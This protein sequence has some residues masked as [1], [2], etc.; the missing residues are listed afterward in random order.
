MC[1]RDLFLV[2]L[3]CPRHYF[4]LLYITHVIVI[5]SPL[6][7]HISIFITVKSRE[8]VKPYGLTSLGLAARHINHINY[9]IL[10]A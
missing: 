3:K 6:R 4:S 8:A 7:S 2:G 10:L 9:L 1:R 5:V